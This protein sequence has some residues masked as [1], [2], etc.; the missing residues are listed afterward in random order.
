MKRCPRCYKT[1][2]DN[3]LNFCLD[4]GELLLDIGD[5]T[6]QSSFGNQSPPRFGDDAPPTIIL[7][8]PRI[9]NQTTWRPSE[10]ISPWQSQAPNTQNPPYGSPAFVQSRDQTLS[11]VSLALGIFGIM[12]MCCFGGIP[13]GAAAL[14]TGYLGMKN[15]DRDPMKYGARGLAVAGLILGIVGFLGSFV[16]L[17]IALV[18]N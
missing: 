6:I 7:D 10:P 1:Y 17:I 9:T 11:T 15:A 3:D 2:T 16:Y 8:T 13:F 12:S 5:D 4:D 14:I 18:A